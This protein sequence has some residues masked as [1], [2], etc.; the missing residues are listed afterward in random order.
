MTQEKLGPTD[1]SSSLECQPDLTG[2][3]M[4]GCTV[5]GREEGTANFWGPQKPRQ[6]VMASPS[7]AAKLTVDV[8]PNVC[9]SSWSFPTTA[10]GSSLAG[11]AGTE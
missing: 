5:Q 7:K 8:R 1:L 4:E 3:R 9:T 10:A 11:P 2:P 6:H